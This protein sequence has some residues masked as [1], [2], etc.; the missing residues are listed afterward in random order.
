M[1]EQKINVTFSPSIKSINKN[2]KT[3]K[4]YSWV[5]I[6][7]Q[8]CSRPNRADKTDITVLMDLTFQ[9]RETDSRTLRE[10][11]GDCKAMVNS[12]RK[13]TAGNGNVEYGA[14]VGTLNKAA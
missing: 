4:N 13:F 14:I 1:S 11:K 7:C 10:K 9:S 5:S 2:K 6:L 3:V 12:M 8:S